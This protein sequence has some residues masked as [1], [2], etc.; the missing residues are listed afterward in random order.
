MS[1]KTIFE[2]V[3]TSTELINGIQF[4]KVNESLLKV[5][6]C[7]IAKMN[8]SFDTSEIFRKVDIYYN[9]DICKKEL[10][11]LNIDVTK[12]IFFKEIFN[13]NE[14][15]VQR[16]IQVGKIVFKD[17]E[18][19]KQYLTS[20]RTLSLEDFIKFSKNEPENVGKKQTDNKTKVNKPKKYTSENKHVE[21]KVF[22]G[23][24]KKD[25]AELVKQFVTDYKLT[26]NDIFPKTTKK[27]T[28]KVAKKV[29][30]KTK[31]VK[32]VGGFEVVNA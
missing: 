25:I 30:K 12:T 6:K 18:L 9:S 24:T 26:E 23:T 20:L 31:V 8:V 32:V 3:Q 19:K 22:E 2:K 21:A 11:R 15:M 13:L 27:V 16:Y 28:K 7:N 17:K 29:A 4:D 14:R 5:D 1:T 10:T